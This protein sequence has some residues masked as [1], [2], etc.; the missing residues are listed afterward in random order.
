MRMYMWINFQTPLQLPAF[1]PHRPYVFTRAAELDESGT[2]MMDR[3]SLAARCDQSGTMCGLLT[4][5]ANPDPDPEE[6]EDDLHSAADV[7]AAGVF[8]LVAAAIDVEAAGA[9]A[10]TDED[11][12][13]EED[14]DPELE[15]AAVRNATRLKCFS[16]RA[17]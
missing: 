1:F 15:A 2:G 3:M 10:E 7:D 11:D 12:E 8:A 17:S 16:S 5:A 14:E 13:E 9:S 6:E 4:G